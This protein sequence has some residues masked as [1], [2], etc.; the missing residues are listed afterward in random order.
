VVRHL[1]PGEDSQPTRWYGRATVHAVFL[2]LLIMRAQR[3]TDAATIG[4]LRS[5]AAV[6][7]VCSILS[8]LDQGTAPLREAL[9]RSEV[10]VLPTSSLLHGA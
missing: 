7:Y 6:G 4:A 9:R 3:R 5:P 2:T 10:R 1:G 8:S